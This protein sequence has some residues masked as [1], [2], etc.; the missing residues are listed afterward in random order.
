MYTLLWSIGCQAPSSERDVGRAP[1]SPPSLPTDAPPPISSTSPPPDPTSPSSPPAGRT[2]ADCFAGQWGPDPSVDYDQFGPRL[3]AHCHGTDHQDIRDVERVVYVGD[4][5]TVGTPPTLGAQWWRNQTADALAQRFGLEA[6]TGRWRG[7]DVIDGVAGEA[8]SGDFAS[9]AKWGARTDD[10]LLDPHRQ[11]ETCLP[12]EQRG[13]RTLVLLSVGGND[14]YSL[15]E[16][17]RAGVDEATLRATYDQ[18]LQRLREAV[19]WVVDPANL[20]NGAYVVFANTY[21]LTDP[22]G[23]EDVA[24]CD[25]ARLIGMDDPLRDP[26]V[27]SIL[28]DAQEAY[29]QLAVETGTDVV[30]LGEAFCGHGYAAGDPG[31]RCYRGP[32]AELWLDLTCEH[33]NGRGHD[34]LTEAFLAVVDE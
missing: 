13:A 23:A 26:I 17:A 12:P 7:V 34:A 33:P 27:Q 24:R 5:I 18:A 3:G 22:H 19:E 21:D 14:I 6:P 25:G 2:A 11:L 9:C 10:L 4:S 8:V 31:G 29:V 30:F 28:A 32:D 1:P 15:L 16:D 20:P